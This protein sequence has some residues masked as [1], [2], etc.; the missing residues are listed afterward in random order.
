MSANVPVALV[1][2]HAAY[3]II[4]ALV[5][6]V[7]RRVRRSIERAADSVERIARRAA[8][9]TSDAPTGAHR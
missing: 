7:A 8:S 5:V 1:A 3:W 9:P 4:A 6:L 2:T